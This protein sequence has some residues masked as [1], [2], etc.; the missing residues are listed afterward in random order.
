MVDTSTGE[1]LV[2]ARGEGVSKKGGGVS[3]GGFGGG[4]GG[5]F[6]MGSDEY[7][8][9]ALGEAQAQACTDLVQK[10]VAKKDRLEEE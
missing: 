5:G 7:K 10:L 9:S 4:V 2:S 3:V 1:I 6:S 8:A